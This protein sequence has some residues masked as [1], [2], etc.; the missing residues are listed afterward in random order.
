[1]RSLGR[2]VLTIDDEITPLDATLAELVTATA[3]G[4]LGL[5]G[6]GVD[7]AAILCVAAGDNPQRVRSEAAWAHLC[8]IAPLEATSGKLTRRHRLNGG[9]RQANHALGRI[10][11][12]RL[13]SDARTR[14]YLARRLD[15]GPSRP[16]IIRSLKPYVARETYRHLPR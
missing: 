13:G 8:G 11:F 14:T 15:Q 2:R 10:V 7:T 1:M 3:P 12:T 16:E 9:N 6:V 5:H 4:L